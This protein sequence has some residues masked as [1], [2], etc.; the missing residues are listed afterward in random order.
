MASR[1]TGQISHF[2]ST[3]F[4]DYRLLQSISSSEV[5]IHTLLILPSPQSEGRGGEGGM[6]FV[7]L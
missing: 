2:K 6:Q 7:N 5:K 4:S 3:S 1:G